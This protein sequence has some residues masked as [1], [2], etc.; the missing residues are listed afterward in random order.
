MD[1]LSY[2]NKL[3]NGLKKYRWAVVILLIGIGLMLLPTGKAAS[4]DAAMETT[5]PQQSKSLEDQ[6]EAT[7]SQIKGVGKVKVMLTLKTGEEILYQTDRD[8]AQGESGT[9]RWDT[10]IITNGD[11]AQAGLI[12][13]VKPPTYRGAIIV[14]QGGNSPAVRLAVVEAVS[15][16]TG[17]STDEISVVEMK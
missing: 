14:C 2:K 9:S 12:T 6:L 13:Q 4:K 1:W 16:V 17:L 11:R 15:K 3:M 5:P 8:I 7:L 10:V